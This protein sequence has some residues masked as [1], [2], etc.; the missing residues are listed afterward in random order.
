MLPASVAELPGSNAMV[1]V[2]PPLFANGPRLGL[3]GDALEPARSPGAVNPLLPFVAPIRLCP[4]E[5]KVPQT[6]GPCPL[7]RV[8][9]PA[10]ILFRKTPDP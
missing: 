8:L 1:R 6:S 9:L 3:S 4:S 2:G 5:L 10:T 7:V